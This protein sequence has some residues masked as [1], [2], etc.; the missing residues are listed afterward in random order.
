MRS[1]FGGAD[2]RRATGAAIT[3][4]IAIA[5]SLPY[6]APAHAQARRG[7]AVDR[8]EPVERGSPTFVVDALDVRSMPSGAARPAFG[9]VVDYAYKPLAVYDVTGAERFALVR[10][11]LVLHLG[12]SIVIADRLRAGLHVPFAIHQDGEDAIV[13]GA[14]HRAAT[15]PAIGD[16]RIAADVRLLGRYGEPI[17]V[18]AGMRAWVPTGVAS[19]FTSDGAFRIAPQVLAAGTIGAFVWGARLAVIYRARDDVYAGSQ[20]GSELF[21][22][23]MAGLR[24]A[25]G[26][27]QIGPELWASSGFT[28]GATFLGKRESAVGWILGAHVT[29]A[30]GLRFGGGIGSGLG[31]GLGSPVVRVLAS[32]E[33]GAPIPRARVPDR[34]GHEEVD[35]F[36]GFTNPPPTHGEKPLAVV[37][38]SEIAIGESIQFVTDSA[39]L[40]G[41]SDAVLGAVATVLREHPEIEKLRVEGHTDAI[42]DPTYNDQLSARRA[43]SVTGWLVAHGIDGGRL[44]SVGLGS[45]RPVAGNDTE[46]GRAKN[47]RVVFTIVERAS[48]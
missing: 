38:E 20:L 13:D 47:R 28:G 46:E 25:D 5:A 45:R 8:F 2:R 6:A 35:P 43:A 37:T 48:P 32:I 15:A 33:W 36:T 17:V 23:V 4:A 19:Q 7:F 12:A 16:V 3:V 27:L 18:A 42:G 24:V 22:A 10:H 44:E 11:Q 26:A 30:S 40:V 29:T 14:I 39:E 34:E 1:S 9:A 21:G 41:D 31:R